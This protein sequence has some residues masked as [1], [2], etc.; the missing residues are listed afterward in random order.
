M[1]CLCSNL[2]F[3]AILERQRSQPLPLPQMLERHTSCLSGCRSCVNSLCD[4]V[5][6][7]GLEPKA[8]AQD[9]ALVT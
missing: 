7:L 5:K 8:L 3:D 9:E 1:Y 4:A 2:S 6:R